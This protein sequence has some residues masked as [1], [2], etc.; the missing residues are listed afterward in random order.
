MTKRILRVIVAVVL[1]WAGPSWSQNLI[2]NSRFMVRRQGGAGCQNCV[3]GPI[4]VPQAGYWFPEAWRIAPGRG[5][6]M[7][8]YLGVGTGPGD[9]GQ[10][11]QLYVRWTRGQFDPALEYGS[12]FL[13]HYIFEFDQMAGHDVQLSFWAKVDGCCVPVVPLMWA[14]YHNGDYEFMFADPVTVTTEW[15]QFTVTFS[16]P[17]GDGHLLDWS[18]YFAVGLTFTHPS[19]PGM[20]LAH[21]GLQL[22]N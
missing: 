1:L 14:N 19:A 13:E 15:Q 5:A 20:H 10:G 18:R 9:A 21:F 12:A 2:Q 16:L 3:I 17:T 8:A 22:L 11:N 4:A 7:Q 6:A